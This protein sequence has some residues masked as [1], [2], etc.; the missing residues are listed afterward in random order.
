MFFYGESI[1]SAAFGSLGGITYTAN[2]AGTSGNS[3]TITHTQGAAAVSA[4]K[5]SKTFASGMVPNNYSFTI[6]AKTAGTIGN[7][8]SIIFTVDNLL[9]INSASA[10]TSGSSITVR[11]RGTPTASQVATAITNST[12]TKIVDVGAV[13]NGNTAFN[14]TGANGNLSGGVNA[15]NAET[16]AV[17]VSTATAIT[18]RIAAAETDVANVVTVVNDAD[19]SVTASGTGS[20]SAKTGSVTLSGG[21][22]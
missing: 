18:V 5:A 7:G 17:T 4:V 20:I 22:N 3:I 15:V 21:S 1:A 19:T 8:Y 11:Y 14:F 6:T 10:N 16:T 9:P 13:T 2:S 12:G